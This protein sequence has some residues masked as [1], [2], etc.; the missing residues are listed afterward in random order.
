M[1]YADKLQ[2]E[3]NMFMASLICKMD[4]DCEK[5]LICK[6][7]LDCV[8]TLYFDTEVGL[9]S[10]YK[11]TCLDFQVLRIYFILNVLKSVAINEMNETFSIVHLIYHA[12][13]PQFWEI[14]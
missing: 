14:L 3:E 2:S 4:I 6:T 1:K 8:K 7:D 12:G 11:F 5:L 10:F 13:E 9:A